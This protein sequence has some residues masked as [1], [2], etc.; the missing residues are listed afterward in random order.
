MSQAAP[1]G[2]TA[3]TD[4]PSPASE[5]PTQ[6]G[7]TKP[8]GYFTND[9]RRMPDADAAPTKPPPAP[10]P[11]L[12]EHSET[13]ATVLAAEEPGRNHWMLMG[14][15]GF[16]LAGIVAAVV[17]FW[18]RPDPKIEPLKVPKPL[19]KLD[20]VTPKKAV[21]APPP[22]AVDP[23]KKT[24]ARPPQPA[25]KAARERPPPSGSSR[26]RGD[27]RKAELFFRTGRRFEK[28]GEVNDALLMYHLAYATSGS[29]KDASIY[30]NLG[31]LHDKDHD[32][33][34]ARACLSAYLERAPAAPQ[35]SA[36]RTR[37]T[38]FGATETVP[39]VDKKELRAAKRQYERRGAMIDGWLD[40]TLKQRLK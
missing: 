35:A 10:G 1:E 16:L 22:A 9:T 8:D 2:S 18:P 19:A 11:L 28:A 23:S 13:R 4:A 7:E 25:A 27:R 34:K 37:I 26:L 14:A 3:A 36:I 30:L 20:P 17:T 21:E 38:K 24:T 6:A 15:V 29:R 40:E 12:P 33:A 39:C 31:L 32:A 5:G